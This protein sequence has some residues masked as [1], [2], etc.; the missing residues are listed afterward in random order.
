MGA[1]EW[2]SVFIG[3]C[4]SFPN[5]FNSSK[6]Q[7]HLLLFARYFSRPKFKKS[8]ISLMTSTYEKHSLWSKLTC[9]PRLSLRLNFTKGIKRNFWRGVG[10]F[11]ERRPRKD[12]NVKRGVGFF[13]KG[14]VESK[15]LFARFSI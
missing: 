5:I 13:L 2:D 12:D 11:H 1:G 9:Y 7:L 6:I 15:I 8:P 10:K 14:L 3:K 4:F